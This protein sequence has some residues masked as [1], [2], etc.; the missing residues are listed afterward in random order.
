MLIFRITLQ[1]CN[2]LAHNIE[3]D[4]S[5]GS[6]ETQMLDESLKWQSDHCF[7]CDGGQQVSS[8]IMIGQEHWEEQEFLVEHT[9]CCS[10]SAWK[11]G[12]NFQECI[13][14]WLEQRLE[15]GYVKSPD[16]IVL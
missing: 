3:L 10:F 2:H 11:I 16:L 9:I 13:I 8:S 15:V 1:C 5:A 12:R 14:Q 4:V 7:L 6:K